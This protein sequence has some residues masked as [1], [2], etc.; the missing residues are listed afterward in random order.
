MTVC[1]HRRNHHHGVHLPIT[2]VEA[3][4]RARIIGNHQFWKRPDH[5][6][7]EFSRAVQRVT[8]R[9][10]PHHGRRTDRLAPRPLRNP[11]QRAHGRRRA[12]WIGPRQVSRSRPEQCRGE[13]RRRSQAGQPFSDC[14]RCQP[15]HAR[16]IT[17]CSPVVRALACALPPVRNRA[18]TFG[19][20]AA[21]GAF[22]RPARAI[23]RQARSISSSRS[24]LC[25]GGCRGFDARAALCA[26]SGGSR[27]GGRFVPA[28][29]DSPSTRGRTGPTFRT[30][31]NACPSGLSPMSPSFGFVPGQEPQ[32]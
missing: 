14:G 8:G 4:S 28:H 31:G 17:P 16:P 32:R 29:F 1:P 5:G 11:S 23:P 25:P 22:A 2:A 21:P 18:M 7:R 3:G 13:R 20:G 26:A 12:S 9:S 30:F 6:H 15:P 10:G 27:A 19:G 24:G